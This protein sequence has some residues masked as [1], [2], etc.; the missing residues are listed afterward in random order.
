MNPC[1][2]GYLGHNKINCRCSS[3]QIKRYRQKIS[4]PLLDRID[5]QVMVP[6]NTQEVINAT[7]HSGESSETVKQRVSEARQHQQQR[8][9]CLNADLSSHQLAL[10]CALQQDNRQLMSQAVDRLGLSARAYHRTLKVAR[11]IADLASSPEIESAHLLEA[12][13]LRNMEL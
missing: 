1:P 5:L 2:C 3:E 4:G 12:L 11:T 10:Y 8:Q 7:Q 6:A 13:N 9:D